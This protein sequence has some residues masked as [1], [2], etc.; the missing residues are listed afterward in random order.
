MTYFLR[1]FGEDGRSQFVAIPAFPV[2][3]FRHGTVYI[4]KASGIETPRD[5]A[6]KRIG[7]LGLYG[8]DAGVMPKG[9]L[10]DEFGARPKQS[11]CGGID[12]PMDP[13]DFVH[14][15]SDDSPMHAMT[16]RRAVRCPSGTLA[17][18]GRRGRGP[19][20]VPGSRRRAR[21]RVATGIRMQR[22]QRGRDCWRQ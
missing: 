3:S 20:K 5:F 13:I 11:R 14:R 8:H 12:F 18:Q 15:T 19:R 16:N 10:S 7:E 21:T 6:G 1:T 9:I 4:N 22:R 17:C 2:R